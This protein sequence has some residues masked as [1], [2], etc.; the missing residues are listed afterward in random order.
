MYK[1][2][3]TPLYNAFFSEFNYNTIQNGIISETKA[4][5]GKDINEQDARPLTIIMESI[6]S[7]NSYNPYGDIQAQVESMNTQ[8][9]REC[10]RQTVMGVQAYQRYIGDLS[11]APTPMSNPEMVSTYGNKMPFNGKIGL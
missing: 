3:R 9:I 5:T 11:S 4:K 7:V 2:S 8:V 1:Q 10:T 6:Y